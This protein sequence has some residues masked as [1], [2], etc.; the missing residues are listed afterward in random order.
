MDLVVSYISRA[1]HLEIESNFWT[2][3]RILSNSGH[4]ITFP[5]L[6]TLVTCPPVDYDFDYIDQFFLPTQIAIGR[7]SEDTPSALRR[8]AIMDETISFSG[9]TIPTQWSTLTHMSI[10]NVCIPHDFWVSLTLAVP[11]LQWAYFC[12]DHQGTFDAD[13]Y[14]NPIERTLPQLSALFIASGDSSLINTLFAGLHLPALKDL[15][16]SWWNHRGITDINT[17]LR[18]AP[19]LQNLTLRKHNHLFPNEIDYA[20]GTHAAVDEVAPIWHSSPHLAHLCLELRMAHSGD[21]EIEGRLGHLCSERLLF[22]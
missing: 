22:Q 6:H 1:E 13:K 4:R 3:V 5:N 16:L 8:L 17:V 15:F 14:N 12:Y 7:V 10:N 18:S 20:T 2:Q 21:T 19:A 11:C 9:T